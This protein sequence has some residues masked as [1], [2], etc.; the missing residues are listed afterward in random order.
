MISLK[1]DTVNK[2]CVYVCMRACVYVC[3]SPFVKFPWLLYNTTVR[4]HYEN[5]TMA[6]YVHWYFYLIIYITP[7]NFPFSQDL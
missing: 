4:A 2:S 3:V 7:E 1:D 5:R 6:Y